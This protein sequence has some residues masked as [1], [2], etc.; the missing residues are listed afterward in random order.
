MRARRARGG[1]RAGARRC[2]WRNAGRS[3]SAA[4]SSAPPRRGRRSSGDAARG[5]R[6]PAARVSHGPSG[7]P[8]REHL[9]RRRRDRRP[10]RH[11]AH[12]APAV[13]GRETEE[14]F[15][16][17]LDVG[18]E[19]QRHAHGQGEADHRRQVVVRR[20]D[21]DLVHTGGEAVAQID[22]RRLAADEQALR[23]VH[24]QAVH[25]DEAV[26]RLRGGGVEAER[27]ALPEPGGGDPRARGVRRRFEREA[28]AREHGPAAAVRDGPARVPVIGEA[29]VDVCVAHALRWDRTRSDRRRASR[30]PARPTPSA[31]SSDS[32]TSRAVGS[33]AIV[34]R[35]TA[36]GQTSDHDA[37]LRRAVAPMDDGV[38]LDRA[39]PVGSRD[40]RRDAAARRPRPGCRASP[41]RRQP[42]GGGVPPSRRRAR[43]W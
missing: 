13:A 31:H 21:A 3:S 24:Q 37:A 26:R 8:A 1:S 9:P 38:G 22:E 25:R 18:L 32:R 39:G 27:V 28:R 15:A 34:R 5:W 16:G 42:C 7:A 29:R 11:D 30:R 35:S 33:A 20:L 40:D 6:K 19:E 17:H 23:D 2:S 10:R 12:E 14:R 41:A 43:A 36:A 4:R